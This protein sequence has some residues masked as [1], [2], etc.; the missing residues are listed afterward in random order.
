MKAMQGRIP[1]L[2]MVKGGKAMDMLKQFNQG[3]EWGFLLMFES[4][5][6]VSGYLDHPVHKP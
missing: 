1:G 3:Y 6:A 4:P 2:L 5:D